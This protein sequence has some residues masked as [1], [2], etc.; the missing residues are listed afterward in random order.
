MDMRKRF[1]EKNLQL[2]ELQL[3]IGFDVAGVGHLGSGR[4]YPNKDSIYFYSRFYRANIKQDS[5][6]I[7]LS[8]VSFYLYALLILDCK[9]EITTV[10]RIDLWD[11]FIAFNLLM[12]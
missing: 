10:T 7:S 1:S 6:N 5:L 12:P 4:E 8:K 3:Y 2:M 11:N 9:L